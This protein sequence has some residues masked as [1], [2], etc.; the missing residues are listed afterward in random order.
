MFALESAIRVVND[1]SD[2]RTSL[3]AANNNTILKTIPQAYIE[4]D[5]VTLE[6][7]YR[8][9]LECSSGQNIYQRFSQNSCQGKVEHHLAPMNC[10]V[11]IVPR[12]D[13]RAR[14]HF[15]VHCN[16]DQATF[17][18]FD[19][20]KMTMITSVKEGKVGFAV[21]TYIPEVDEQLR[22]KGFLPTERDALFAAYKEVASQRPELAFKKSRKRVP[23]GDGV[24]KKLPVDS[25]SFTFEG[26]DYILLVPLVHEVSFYNQKVVL[27]DRF[28]QKDLEDRA[29]TENLIV[30]VEKLRLS[31]KA[32]KPKLADE[33]DET[34]EN[35]YRFFAGLMG[36]DETLTVAPE[37]FE[38]LTVEET[39]TIHELGQ[40]SLRKTS[41]KEIVVARKR[42]HKEIAPVR[43]MARR[44]AIKLDIEDTRVV[45]QEVIEE[46]S[47]IEQNPPNIDDPE[48]SFYTWAWM[49]ARTMYQGHV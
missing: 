21:L 16:G 4:V 29:V 20:K 27:E 23:E 11:L 31:L 2:N 45:E 33:I 44:S 19:G 32:K 39:S 15:K 10:G 42:S 34:I 30:E 35:V 37:M 22:R 41:R 3:A 5:T 1:S 8:M 49:E 7:I 26:K 46:F 47:L 25:V 17:D 36:K 9:R 40:P 14:T 48:D 24:G 38:S 43:K 13:N 12:N 6:A 28:R 18:G